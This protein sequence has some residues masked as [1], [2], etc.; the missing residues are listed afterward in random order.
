M[1]HT[2]SHRHNHQPLLEGAVARSEATTKL[3]LIEA[4]LAKVE[5]ELGLVP[6]EPPLS[7]RHLEALPAGEGAAHQTRVLKLQR[8]RSEVLLL[9]SSRGVSVLCSSNV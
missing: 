8:E 9:Y 4:E 7:T 5:G 2:R 3:R 6:L 1:T